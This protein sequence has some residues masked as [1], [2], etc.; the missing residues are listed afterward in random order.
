MSMRDFEYFLVAA[1]TLN[2]NKASERLFITQQ[3][4]SSHIQKMERDYHVT[5]FERKPHLMLTPAGRCMLEYARRA[6]QLENEL[7]SSLADIVSNATGHLVIGI[8]GIISAVFMPPIWHKFHSQYPNIS[9][10]IV[11]ASKTQLEEK[12]QKGELDIY[13]AFNASDQSGEKKLTLNQE[14]VYYMISEE[15]GTQYLGKNWQCQ[16]AFS[17]IHDGLSLDVVKDMPFIIYPLPSL[18]RLSFNKYFESSNHRPHIIFETSRHD[19]IFNLCLQGSGIGL[20]YGTI[21]CYSLQN[22]SNLD[23]ICIFPAKNRQYHYTNNLVY[24]EDCFLPHYLEQFI[25][26]TVSVFENYAAT[27]DAFIQTMM[28]KKRNP[29]YRQ[30]PCSF[31]VP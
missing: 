10:S 29:S 4:L 13:I 2:F 9:L 5:L 17:N 21:L 3:S 12:L 23:N 14:H 19:L 7:S 18:L 24:R 6:L 22:T 31:P 25:N 1:E 27:S 30:R 11:D 15:L 16:P 8:N 28:K 20:M 26:I